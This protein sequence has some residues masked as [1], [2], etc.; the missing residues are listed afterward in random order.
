L[1][2][3]RG[4]WWVGSKQAVGE[5]MLDEKVKIG[6]GEGGKRVIEGGKVRK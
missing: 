4:G 6:V 5:P 3:F 2:R 1:V